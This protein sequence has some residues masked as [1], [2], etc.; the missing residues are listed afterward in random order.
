MG[1]A[2]AAASDSW[3]P[4][5]T[6]VR[7][8]VL[9]RPSYEYR[10]QYADVTLARRHKQDLR[11]EPYWAQVHLDELLRRRAPGVGPWRGHSMEEAFAGGAQLLRAHAADLLAGQNLHDLDAIVA[12]RP[13]RGVPGL[14]FPVAEPWALSQEGVM[15][16]TDSELPRDMAHE[17]GRSRSD[18]PTIRAVAALKMVIAGRGTGDEGAVAAGHARLHELLRDADR[19][20]RRAAASALG[21]WRDADAL[22]EVLALLEQEPADQI[23]PVAAAAT[24]IALDG[25]DDDRRRTLDALRLFASRGDV[26]AAQVAELQ[27]RLEGSG[28][29]PRVVRLA[30]GPDG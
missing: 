20:V 21:E 24:F 1:Y 8:D 15:F 7:G 12:G 4:T 23:S 16:T 10:D 3:G 14:D 9:V 26:G 27:P 2:V 13:R 28:G 17:I 5:A 6:Y 18:D 25:S 11:E 22:D 29:Y 19:D 30:R